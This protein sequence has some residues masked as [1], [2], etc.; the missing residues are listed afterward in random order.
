MSQTTAPT[1][2]Q[3]AMTMPAPS[4]KFAVLIA[5]PAMI[6]LCVSGYLAYT[7]LTSSTVA[8]CSGSLF[9]C[10]SVLKS[11]WARWFGIP[12]SMLAALTYIGLLGSLAVAEPVLS[13]V[14]I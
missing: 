14:A 13:S 3:N 4:R 6:A 10:H 8:G 12:V 11:R 9:D 7:T 2:W 5:I 1:W